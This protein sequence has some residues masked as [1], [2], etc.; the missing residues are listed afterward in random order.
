MENNKVSVKIYGHEYTIAGNKTRDHIIK[1]ADFV[2]RK[3]HEIAKALPTGSTADLAVLS[4]VNIADD[5]YTSIDTVNELKSQNEQ[6]EKDSRHYVQ[7]WEEAKKSFLQYKEDAQ[8][9]IEQ[10]EALQKLFNEKIIEIDQLNLKHKEIEDK[11]NALLNKNED[12][13]DRM[14]EE[15][16]TKRSTSSVLKELE[17]KY[18]DIESSFFDLQMENIQLKGEL[19]RYKKNE[20]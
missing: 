11:Y 17:A 7:L 12:L 20:E 10:K 4:A 5:Y 3:M 8:V 16:E 9:T 19:D 1:V 2:D 6:L 14:K 13:A 18:K 15:E